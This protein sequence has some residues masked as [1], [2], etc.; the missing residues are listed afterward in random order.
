MSVAAKAELTKQLAALLGFEDGIADVLEMLLTIET[1]D[2]G[3]SSFIRTMQP[4]RSTNCRPIYS[5][6]DLKVYLDQLLGTDKDMLPFIEDVERVKQGGLP[7]NSAP[8]NG[9]KPS[10]PTAP[11][12][13]KNVPSGNHQNTKPVSKSF[14]TPKSQQIRGHIRGNVWDKQQQ[15]KSAPTGRKNKNKMDSNNTAPTYQQ[16]TPTTE[17][18]DP[19][20]YTSRIAQ[21][22]E[23]A[24]KVV[25]PA[26][27]TPTVICGCFGT[28]HRPLTNCLYCGRISCEREGYSYCGFC[29]YLVEKS[30][31]TRYGYRCSWCFGVFVHCRQHL[32]D[33]VCP[34]STALM[35]LGNTKSVYCDMIE[36]PPNER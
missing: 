20:Q 33:T 10:T 17:R 35:Q 5:L 28:L 15:V 23:K 25:A 26:H 21:L 3:H 7:L 9:N 29:G 14:T 18:K 34:F 36:S 11:H 1:K 16:A 13:H 8:Q 31:G 4:V 2:V 24:P 19:P 27:G 22:E 6:Q 32:T 12:Q 30:E